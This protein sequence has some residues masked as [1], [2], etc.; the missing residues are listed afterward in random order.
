[1]GWGTSN[2]K[3]DKKGPNPVQDLKKKR[4]KRKRAISDRFG[5][6]RK[7]MKG[8]TKKSGQMQKLIKWWMGGGPREP[9]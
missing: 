8:R 1:V 9:G 6:P 5:N 2:G 7:K 4:A 3:K